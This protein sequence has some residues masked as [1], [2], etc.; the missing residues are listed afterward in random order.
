LTEIR[1]IKKGRWGFYLS[2]LFIWTYY[3]QS[4]LL[5]R[6]AELMGLTEVTGTIEEGKEQDFISLV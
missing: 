3:Y 6:A 5:S 2:A 1:S 4:L